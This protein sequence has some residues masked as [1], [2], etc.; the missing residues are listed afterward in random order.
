MAGDGGARANRLEVE[1]S[2][3]HRLVWSLNVRGVLPSTISASFPP[4]TP[5]ISLANVVFVVYSS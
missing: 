5:A 4:S 3:M 1:S 2:V